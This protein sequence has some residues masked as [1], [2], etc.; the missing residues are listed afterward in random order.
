MSMVSDWAIMC[1][2]IVFAMVFTYGCLRVA[3][4]IA[5]RSRFASSSQFR[6]IRFWPYYI[7]AS[8][9]CAMGG[10]FIY[11]A[12]HLSP[13]IS[14]G[15]KTLYAA[16]GLGALNYVVWPIINLIVVDF[17]HYWK[18]RAEHRFFW[19]FHAVHHSIENLSAVNSYH[20][21]TDPLFSLVLAT[22]PMALVVGL[23]TP[24]F[25]VLT[26]LIGAQGP[27]I[28]ANTKLHFG[29]MARLLVDNRFHRIHH[30][31]E[32]RHFDRNFGER[33]TIW[34]QIFRTAY[35]PRHDEWPN[36][37]IAEEP[38]PSLTSDYFWRPFKRSGPGSTLAGAPGRA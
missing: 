5:P 34:D 9:L 20:H 1:A 28:H 7:A 38:E 33:S 24:T 4:M 18:H 25:A 17:F 10:N 15:G 12:F 8:A 2:G 26:V 23:D 14:I 27:F 22:I 13:L 29:P 6:S 3:E 36:T 35:F 30:S 16:T 31:V 21:W 19:K 37:G 11:T 32:T